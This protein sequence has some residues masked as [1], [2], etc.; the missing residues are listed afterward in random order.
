MDKCKPVRVP[1]DSNFKYSGEADPRF[2]T[3]CR[4]L[5]GALLYIS[6]C[7]RPDSM[8]P[9]NILARHQHIANEN[10]WIAL[11]RFL[12]Y[13]QGTV[14]LSFEFP[15]DTRILINIEAYADADADWAG[16]TATRKSTSGYII[17]LFGCL[18]LWQSR[19]QSSVS[20]STAESEYIFASQNTFWQVS[21]ALI[22]S[23]LCMD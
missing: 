23:G 21:L 3:K 18:V 4:S 20:L 2:E 11:K 19:R 16:D 5:I 7:S 13:L 15:V 12:C 17:K 22:L 6:L 14:D 9:V 8:V 1:I 10:L